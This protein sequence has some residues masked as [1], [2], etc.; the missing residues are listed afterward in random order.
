MEAIYIRFL[1][2]QSAGRIIVFGFL[3]VILVG[4]LLL[5]LP[6]SRKIEMPYID[7][8][9]TAT[10][11]VCV[12]GLVVV[13][14]GS[15]FTL[16]GQIVICILIQI[17][18]LGVASVGAGLIMAIGGKLNLKGR[19][20]IKE[21]VNFDSGKGIIKFLRQVLFITF[22]IELTGAVLSFFVFIKDYPF[23]KS[24][25]LSIFHSVASFNNAGF[26]ILGKGMSL[27]DYRTNIPMNL[28][29]SVLVI[30]GG[31]GFLVI[32]DVCRN[33]FKFKKFRY[34]SKVV[35]T[36]TAILLAAG[37]VL[38]KITEDIS[39][40]GAFFAS[41][42]ARTAGFVTDPM[43]AFSNAGILIMCLLMFIG[44]SSGSTGGGVKTGTIF[45][46]FQG[47]RSAATNRK[48]RLF[49]YSIPKNSYYKATVVVA[50][51]FTVVMVGIILMSIFEPQLGLRDILFEIVSAVATV[52]LSTGITGTLSVASKILT[53]CIMF[54]GR[55]G[56]LTIA[57]LWY[58]AQDE[59][60]V[61]PEGQLLIG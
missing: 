33:R 36:V 15:S 12:T 39:W 52:G 25:W 20:L 53:I 46:L 5:S 59:R 32:G 38:L 49:K 3:A 30:L 1:K 61:Y 6:F 22:V 51:G 21:G 11:A 2:K 19:A 57:S 47:I 27:Y 16:F 35:I 4:S 9:Y 18:G 10:S 45:V 26:D 48:S 24:V 7:C 43:G 50:L 41:M 28:I 8:L 56:P 17:G 23:I 54:I 13:D 44:A 37:T 60:A 55:L 29:T 58:F 34:Q 31:L 40:L 14:T 42:S